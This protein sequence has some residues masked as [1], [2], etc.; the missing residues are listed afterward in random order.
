MNKKPYL[1]FTAV[2]FGIVGVLHLWRASMGIPVVVG[3]GEFPIWLSWCGA[4]VAGGL[5]FW[6]LRLSRQ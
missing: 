1:F 2:I 6:G 4:V 5:S 3:E